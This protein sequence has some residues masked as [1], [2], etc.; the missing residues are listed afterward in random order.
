MFDGPQAW[1]DLEKIREEKM[2]SYVE[3]AND[4]GIAL[5][6]LWRLRDDPSRGLMFK[7]QRAIRDYIKENNAPE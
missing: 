5:G 6:T 2:L 3:L 1:E 7:T 4:I